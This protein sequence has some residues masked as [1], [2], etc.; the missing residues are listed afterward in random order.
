VTDAAA[1][2]LNKLKA[3]GGKLALSD[4]SSPEE[5]YAVLAM[6]K[7]TFKKAIGALYREGKIKLSDTFIELA[8]N[9]K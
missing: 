9:G 1:I 7:K 3:A 8:G 2:L 6:S 5:V 4:K